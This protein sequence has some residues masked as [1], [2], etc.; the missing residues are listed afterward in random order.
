MSCGSQ[1][2][3]GPGAKESIHSATSSQAAA[4][5]GRAAAANR[6]RPRLTTPTYADRSIQRPS[7]P[8]GRIR[9]STG[10]ASKG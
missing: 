4:T 6:P 2:R 1:S 5:L 10:S 7:S 9:N 3:K 8:C